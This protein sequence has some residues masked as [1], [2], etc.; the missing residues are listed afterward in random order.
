MAY[1]CWRTARSLTAPSGVF[2]GKNSKLNGRRMA[3]SGS[4]LCANGM[5]EK[6]VVP[7]AA[8]DRA[9]EPVHHAQTQ[10]SACLPQTLLDHCVQ[11]RVAPDTAFADLP[12][13]QFELRLDEH[14][15]IASGREELHDGGQHQRL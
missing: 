12:G 13:L 9:V 8:F 6:F 14:E 5:Q 10:S 7:I 4:P 11:G 1:N 15:Q 2:V 3:N